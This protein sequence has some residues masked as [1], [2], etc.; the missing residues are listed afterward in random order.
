MC[1]QV[2]SRPVS[3]CGKGDLRCAPRP[4]GLFHTRTVFQFLGYGRPV[5]SSQDGLPVGDEVPFAVL[6][7][8]VGY[9]RINKGHAELEKRVERFEN[10]RQ[11][12]E[13]RGLARRHLRTEPE[14]KIFAVVAAEELEEERTQLKVGHCKILLADGNDC[15]IESGLA[16]L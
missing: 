13:R 7:R 11:A 15:G 5:G 14:N 16:R 4:R 12:F 10:I 3:G 8:G 6:E 9:N 2:L 1:E